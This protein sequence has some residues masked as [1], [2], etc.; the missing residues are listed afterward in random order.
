[1]MQQSCG[2]ATEDH[3]HPVSS[4]QTSALHTEVS[5]DVRSTHSIPNR[6]LVFSQEEEQAM[7]W[8]PL[9]R[10]L[11]LGGGDEPLAIEKPEPLSFDLSHPDFLPGETVEDYLKRYFG[12]F[13]EV[14]A[15]LVAA[16][17]LWGG[18][19]VMDYQNQR[20]YQD[21]DLRI[22]TIRTIDK[23]GKVTD[24]GST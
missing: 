1:M 22:G 21:Y 13:H 24:D 19:V 5:P 15:E 4:H 16:C 6:C 14:T 18:G 2:V 3:T 9:D 7:T 20:A 10:N 11:P 12:H 17:L 8:N 23:D